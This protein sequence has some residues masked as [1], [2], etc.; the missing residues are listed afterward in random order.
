MNYGVFST[1]SND[2]AGRGVDRGGDTTICTFLTR[3]PPLGFNE[4]PA[5][6]ISG[7]KT[8]RRYTRTKIPVRPQEQEPEER[9]GEVLM[10]RQFVYV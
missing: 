2:P 8:F 4:D 3:E 1:R 9:E 5:S 6:P 7:E 10:G